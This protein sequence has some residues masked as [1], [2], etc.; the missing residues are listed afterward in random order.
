VRPLRGV[1]VLLTVMAMAGCASLPTGSQVQSS[2]AGSN[3]Q[4]YDDPFVRLIPVP[5]G[6]DWDPETIVTAYLTA[7]AAFDD[8]HQ[9]ARGYLARGTQW[10]P[11]LKTI[12]YDDQT[13]LTADEPPQSGNRA[14]VT[15][16]GRQ[17]GTIRPDGQYLAAPT[18]FTENFQLQLNS[19]KQWRISQLPVDLVNG[20]LM[21]QDDTDRAFRTLNLY[22]FSQDGSVVVPNSV[23]VPVYSRRELARQLVT[24]LVAGPTSWL[25]NAVRTGFPGG[26]QLL[27]LGIDNGTATVNLSRQARSGDARS[28]LIQLLWTL[29]K[30]LPEVQSVKLKIAGSPVNVSVGNIGIYDPDA[31]STSSNVPAFLRYPDGRLA[32]L[33]PGGEAEVAQKTQVNHPSVSY[34]GTLLASLDA[35]GHTLT[36]TNLTT[37]GTVLTKTVPGVFTPPSWDRYKNLW[38]VESDGSSSHLWTVPSGKTTPVQMDGWELAGYG[39]RAFRISRDGVRAAAIVQGANSWNVELG[40]VQQG[41]NGPQAEGFITIS[42][43]IQAATDLAWKSADHLAVIGSAQGSASQFVYDVPTSGAPVQSLS[44]PP[45]AGPTSVAADP[46]HPLLVQVAQADP[47]TGKLENLVCQLGSDQFS[48]WQ[49]LWKGSEPGYPG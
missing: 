37:G 49:C 41:P 44:A 30:Q 39:V 45:G 13:K 9:V 5:P 15:I 26:T 10:N 29:T 19:K 18:K 7:S 25:Q 22:F 14:T 47:A 35:S 21:G 12:V 27:G 46:G 11:G 4:P 38:T 32:Y 36:V 42:A 23:F 2:K 8:D 48:T 40:R 33:K 24:Q 31:A 34:D 6:N 17:L 1:I 20:L 3:A 43:E 16:T 28:M